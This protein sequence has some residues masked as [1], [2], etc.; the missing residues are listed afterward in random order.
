MLPKHSANPTSSARP[1]IGK[2]PGF[3]PAGVASARRP[4]G[5]APL[6]LHPTWK[7]PTCP[8]CGRPAERDTDTMDTFMCSSW[9]HLRYLSPQA[10]RS[11]FA[12]DEYDYWMPVDTY[13]GGAE[14]ATMHLIY[15]RFFHKAFRDMG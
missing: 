13:T 8:M 10:E 12:Q 3:S 11:P 15:T 1:R 6:K 9:Y 7:L 4:T 2:S 14:H 5:E